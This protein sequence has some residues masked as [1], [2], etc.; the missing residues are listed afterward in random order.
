MSQCLLVFTDGC[1]P[2]RMHYFALVNFDVIVCS[3]LMS[4]RDNLGICICPVCIHT[5][6]AIKAL[7]N[8]ELMTSDLG[9][10]RS[11]FTCPV[12]IGIERL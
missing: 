9:S 2:I 6:N 7:E 11:R 10:L 8:M 1:V 12:L 5:F 3:I 4:G